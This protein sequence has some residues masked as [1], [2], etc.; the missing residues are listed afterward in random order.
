MYC[1]ENEV[2]KGASTFSYVNIHPIRNIKL[3][4]IEVLFVN[5]IRIPMTFYFKQIINVH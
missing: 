1:S 4:I 2:T 3:G 5:I